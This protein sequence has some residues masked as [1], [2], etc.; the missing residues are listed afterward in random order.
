ML[1]FNPDSEILLCSTPLESDNKNQL[2]FATEAAQEEYFLSTVV[3]TYDGTTYQ[4]KD[5]VIRINA[6][7]EDLYNCNYV[8]YQNRNF[9]NKW[10]YAFITDM[11]FLNNSTTAITIETDVFQTWMFD[12]EIKP[13]FVAREHTNDDTIGANI[14]PETLDYG[15]YV[16]YQ[17]DQLIGSSS[18]IV[19]CSSVDLTDTSFSPVTGN[20]YSGIY[21][22]CAFFAYHNTTAGRN[23]LGV[24]LAGLT[25][26]NKANAITA[27]TMMSADVVG[28]FTDGSQIQPSSSAY[29]ST[30]SVSKMY[31]SIDGYVPR[32]N[33]LFTYPYNLLVLT[34]NAGQYVNLKYED[35][36]SS[37]CSFV[38]YGDVSTNPS[39]AV[40]PSNYKGG[41]WSNKVI[42]SEWPLCNWTYS[43]FDAWVASN[44]NQLANNF[45]SALMSGALSLAQGNP[46][47]IL[48]AAQNI[49]GQYASWSDKETMPPASR[50]SSSGSLLISSG[51]AGIFY[52]KR[53]IK[54]DIARS[55]DDFF[56]MFGYATNRVKVPNIG[57]RQNWNYVETQHINIVG[58]IPNDHMDRLKEVYNSGVTI[59]NNPDTFGDY[60]QANGVV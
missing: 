9:T 48:S 3:R 60:S 31:N 30:K 21:S 33:K 24:A 2:H 36:T 12:V 1:V 8:M 6:N 59:W 45:G 7:I 52:E 19:A 46:G 16:T 58:D 50:G 54:A 28:E 44:R 51:G 11:T 10:F 47:G 53:T 5:D 13:S 57:T 25:E 34:N 39:V 43:A 23:A 42:T 27:I 38:I 26:A 49:A 22:G 32:N 18:V 35:F 55:I 37:D 40:I 20:S 14:V 56:T 41:P 15:A 4:R 29:R 17:T